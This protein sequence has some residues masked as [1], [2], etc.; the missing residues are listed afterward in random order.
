MIRV[1]CA[2]GR[3]VAPTALARAADVGNR[4]PNPYD[5]GL[6][7]KRIATA[8]RPHDVV[9][10]GRLVPEKGVQNVLPA[11]KLLN[12]RGLVLALTVVGPGPAAETYRELSRDLA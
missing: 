11:L 8:D 9:F 7:K 5:D 4:N 10:V 3:I 6:F 2:G 1:L 12:Q